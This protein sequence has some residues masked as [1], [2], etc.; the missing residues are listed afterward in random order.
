MCV[1]VSGTA[2]LNVI[3]F[4]ISILIT[5]KDGIFPNPTGCTLVRDADC[6]AGDI[7]W[8]TITVKK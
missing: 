3:I 4:L 5:G 7:R 1:C 8:V 2:K 6:A